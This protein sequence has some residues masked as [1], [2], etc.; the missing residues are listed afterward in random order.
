MAIPPKVEEMICRIE[1]KNFIPESAQNI[2]L[3]LTTEERA[4]EMLKYMDK[5]PEADDYELTIEADR[6]QQQFPRP[7]RNRTK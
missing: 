5:H 6:I 7:R 3:R 4:S 2:M 1:A